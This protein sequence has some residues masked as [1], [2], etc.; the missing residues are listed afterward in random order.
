MDELLISLDPVWT[1]ER[2]ARQA[3]LIRKVKPWLK[4][5]G[6]RTVEGKAKA[7]E[8]RQKALE[9]ARRDVERA[10]RDLAETEKRLALIKGGLPWWEK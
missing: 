4:S 7:S 1:P 5:T 10:R 9:K 8:N 3:E 2:R 6:P